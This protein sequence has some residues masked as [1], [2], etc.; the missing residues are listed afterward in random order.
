MKYAEK[1]SLLQGRTQSPWLPR[2]SIYQCA[3]VAAIVFLC[4]IAGCAEVKVYQRDGITIHENDTSACAKYASGCTTPDGKNVYFSE[5]DPGAFDHEFVFHA[6]NHGR[7]MEPWK[8]YNGIPYTIVTDAGSN[9]DWR[10]GDC[11][12]RPDSGPVRKCD[13]RI[14]L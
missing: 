12:M 14:K 10:N 3:I 8:A 11:M 6:K 5:F 1:L 7:H 9:T 13:G 2:I 4:E